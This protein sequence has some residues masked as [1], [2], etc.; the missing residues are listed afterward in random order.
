[1][2]RTATLICV[3][4][5]LAVSACSGAANSAAPASSS[6]PL[7]HTALPGASAAAAAATPATYEVGQTITVKKD[8]ADWATVTVSDVKVSPSF[9]RGDGSFEM[10]TETGLVFVSAKVDYVA[11]AG[12]VEADAFSWSFFTGST[13]GHQAVVL[14]GPKPELDDVTLSATQKASGYVVAEVPA[15]GVVTAEFRFADWD[16]APVFKMVLRAA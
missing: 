9:D 15:T 6:A 14:Y 8:G 11:I 13:A 7:T 10:P 5:G 2:K 1:V 3:V 12:G 16:D 4:L